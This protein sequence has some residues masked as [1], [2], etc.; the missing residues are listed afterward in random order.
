MY[1]LTTSDNYNVLHSHSSPLIANFEMGPSPHLPLDIFPCIVEMLDHPVYN[2]DALKSCSM[3]CRAFRLICA[4]YMF[5]KI[6]ITDKNSRPRPSLPVDQIKDLMAMNPRLATYIKELVIAY[7]PA[8]EWNNPNLPIILNQLQNVDTLS[9]N[10]GSAGIPIDWYTIAEPLKISLE[11][12]ISSPSLTDLRL[13][14]IT[15]FPIPWILTGSTSLKNLQLSSAQ[16]HQL[17]YQFEG[18][19]ESTITVR[20]NVPPLQLRSFYVDLERSL[21]AARFLLT[22]K[23]PQDGLPVMDFAA[24]E[25]LSLVLEYGEPAQVAIMKMFVGILTGLRKLTLQVSQSYDAVPVNIFDHIHPS[26]LETLECLKLDF[27]VSG[28]P[29]FALAACNELTTL[30]SANSPLQSF[31]LALTLLILDDSHDLEAEVFNT[32][33]KLLTI[34]KFPVLREVILQFQVIAY[35]PGHAEALASQLSRMAKVAFDALA[36]EP[37]IHFDLTVLA[38]G[39]EIY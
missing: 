39:E 5:A 9:L 11:R 12:L 25:S 7:E 19:P 8:V 1:I 3:V 20:P 30:S 34:A 14:G 10:T 6:K 23:W 24:L 27:T 33:A 16:S 29:S 37:S 2:F 26:S 22:A 36:N 17:Y 28:N 13:D 38:M 4:K 35:R 21:R 18:Q 32:L 31:D 15:D